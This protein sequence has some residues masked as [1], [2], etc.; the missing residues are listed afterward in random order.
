MPEYPI[1]VLPNSVQVQ[2]ASNTD[3]FKI[4]QVLENPEERWVNAFVSG[5]PQNVWV[6]VF[7]PENYVSDWTDESIV[8]AVAQWAQATFPPSITR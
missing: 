4:L 7:T 8:D 6:S 3:T 5:A 1:V 2:P